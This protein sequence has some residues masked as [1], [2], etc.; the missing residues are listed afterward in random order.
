MPKE[1]QARRPG[2]TGNE[3]GRAITLLPTPTAN[4]DNKSPEAH[5]RMKA[6]MKGGPWNTITSLGV[7]ARAGFQQPSN[8]EVTSQPSDDGKKSPAP[9]LHPCFVE[10]M[11]GVPVGW[12]DPDCPLSATEFMSRPATSSVRS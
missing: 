3:L 9:H 10:W 1:G 11:I 8:G 6:R 2:P 5:M 7:L 12:S 4:D